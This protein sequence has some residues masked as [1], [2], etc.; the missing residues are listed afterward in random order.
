MLDSA[1]NP[2]TICEALAKNTKVTSGLSQYALAA[3]SNANKQTS[4]PTNQPLITSASKM[5]F[6][7]GKKIKMIFVSEVFFNNIKDITCF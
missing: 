4:Q 5:S 3:S 1:A 7:E 6:Q 2:S